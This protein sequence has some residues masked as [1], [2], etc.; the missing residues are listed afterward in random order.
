MGQQRKFVLLA[1][2][3]LSICTL[4]LYIYRHRQGQTG[5]IDNI[6]ITLSGGVQKQVFYLSRGGR[7]IYDHYFW[8]VGTSKKNEELIQEVAQ[9]KAQL[10]QLNEI[11]GENQRLKTALDFKAQHPQPM[12]AAHVI[13][14][15][16]SPDYV[17]VRIDR[18]KLDGVEVGLGVVSSEGVVGR[19]QRAAPHYSDVLTLIDPSSNLDG[20]IQRSRARG[21]LSGQAKQISCHLKYLDR[22]E[23]VVVNDAV[24][25]TGYSGIFPK[26]ILMGHVTQVTPSSSGLLQSITVKSAVDIYKLE[27]VF[28]VLPAATA[29]KAAE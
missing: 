26:G 27:E 20:I 14:H 19:I 22:L 10:T 8:L 24:V 29:E 2:V 18:G 25:S 6:L 5:L 15:D 7:A 4:A 21:I 16:V 1:F 17:M 23:D 3:T 13:A 28:I 9:L 12:M 11:T